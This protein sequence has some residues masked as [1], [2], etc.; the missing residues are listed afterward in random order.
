MSRLT[1][2]TKP[3]PH[4]P[5]E[6]RG[7]STAV[8]LLILALAAAAVIVLGANSAQPEMDAWASE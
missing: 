7:L 6:P 2:R 1:D 4:G 5:A 8:T 3:R